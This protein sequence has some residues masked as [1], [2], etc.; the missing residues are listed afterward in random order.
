MCAQESE[1]KVEAVHQ[2]RT[3]TRRIEALL[4]ALWAAM[5]R[6]PAECEPAAGA[7][8]RYEEMFGRWRALLRKVRQ[9]AA[10]VRD[11]DVHRKLLGGLIERWSAADSGPEANLHQQAGHLDAWLRS[12]RARAARPLGRRAAKWAGKLDSLV[13]ATS[14]ALAGLPLP[15]GA[16]RRNAG[17]RTA[18]DAFARLS[19]E[20]ELL[21]GEN[22]HDFRKGAKKAR[23]MAEADGADAYAGEVGKAIKRVQDAIGDWHDWEMLAEEARE[24]LGDVELADYLAGARDRRYAEA[25]RITQTMRGRLMGEWRSIA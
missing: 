2:V 23:Y 24:A 17:A 1:P 11:L 15:A 5:A 10:P 6:R 14:E 18:L 25:V 4:E 13:T 9:A 12:H 20:I 22:L 8:E 21:H 7:Q 3:G 16:R 19:A